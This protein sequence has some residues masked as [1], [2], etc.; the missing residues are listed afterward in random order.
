VAVRAVLG[1][2]K[3]IIAVEIVTVEGVAE[4]IRLI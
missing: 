3:D 1:E 2:K 4:N